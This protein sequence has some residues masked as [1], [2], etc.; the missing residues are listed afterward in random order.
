MHYCISEDYPGGRIPCMCPIGH[1][2]NEEDF[3]ESDE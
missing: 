2:H 3:D 1:T